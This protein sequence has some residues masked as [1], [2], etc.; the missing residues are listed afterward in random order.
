MAARHRASLRCVAAGLLCLSATATI[1]PASAA[2]ADPAA[3]LFR[4]GALHDL[5]LELT[6]RNAIALRET[7][8]RWVTATFQ[9]AE[10]PS[11]AVRVRLKGDR[12]SARA[13]EDKPSWT[14]DFAP[15][16][17]NPPTRPPGTANSPGRFFGLSRI[18]LL[19]SVE[20]PSYLHEWLGS[21]VFRSAGI[22]CPRI[23]HARVTLNGRELGLYVFKEGFT[24]EFLQAHFGTA[25]GT[26]F[27]NDLGHDV[28]ERLHRSVGTDP[29]PGAADPLRQIAVATRETDPEQ[30]WQQLEATLDVDKF[31]TFLALEVVLGHRDGYG[32]G[33]N[34]FRLYAPPAQGRLVFL[35]DGLDQLLGLPDYPWRPGMAGLV[36]RAV[37]D[38]EA[39]RARYRVR[40]TEALDQFFVPDQLTTQIG[41]VIAALRPRLAPPE[42]RSLELESR[43][44]ATRIVERAAS[45]RS[46][47]SQTEPPLLEPAEAGVLL[48]NWSP[49][50]FPDGGRL[51]LANA[52]DGRPSLHFRAGPATSASWRT[53]ARFPPGAYQ[54][55]AR[56]W[57][58]NVAPLAKQ[59][60]A[61]LGLRVAGQTRDEPGLVADSPGWQLVSTGFVVR[62]AAVPVEFLV[63]FVAQA[64]EAW[65]DPQSLRVLPAVR[66]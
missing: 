43:S 41:A 50:D 28:D 55:T 33:K 61:G 54:L 42:R 7:P 46:Q 8:R 11:R 12:G 21:R 45:L 29:A 36:A 3:N 56:G 51:D 24:A 44:L 32:I 53:R 5:R 22:P 16:E 10:A 48:E 15:E 27:D 20:D 4:D 59:R 40:M 26:L 1:P 64:G 25:D 66:R 2:V 57:V 49:K 47:L 31:L 17:P 62:E 37:L 35:P 58:R 13:L 30:R 39:G 6:A 9:F 60:A 52:P 65:V 23:A 63:E 34:N 18:Q 38:T 14:L 19:N